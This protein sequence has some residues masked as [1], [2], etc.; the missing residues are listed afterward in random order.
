[1]KLSIKKNVILPTQAQESRTFPR[2]VPRAKV[3]D[4]VILKM[5]GSKLSTDGL[6]FAYKLTSGTAACTWMVTT[7]V[8]HFTRNGKTVY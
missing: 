2:V 7:I 1:V 6:Q 5:E 8:D 3:F 4:L